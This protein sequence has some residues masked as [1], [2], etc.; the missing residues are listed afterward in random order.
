MRD[1]GKTLQEMGVTMALHRQRVLRGIKRLLLGLG[2]PPSSPIDVHCVNQHLLAWAP[3]LQGGSPPFH[4]YVVEV[5][6]GGSWRVVNGALTSDDRGVR[7]GHEHHH[8]HHQE[9]EGSGTVYRVRAWN[10]YG[11]SEPVVVECENSV[12]GQRAWWSGAWVSTLGVVVLS[13]VARSA[14]MLG[15]LDHT[16]FWSKSSGE[17]HKESPTAAVPPSGGLPRVASAVSSAA[18]DQA[19]PG[20]MQQPPQYTYSASFGSTGSGERFAVP[21]ESSQGA[22]KSSV[23]AFD[24]CTAKTLLPVLRIKARGTHYC[25]VCQRYY[26]AVHTAVSA[27]GASG[28]CGVES[29]CVCIGC[30]DEMDSAR[31]A[32]VMKRRRGSLSERRGF[33][34]SGGSTKSG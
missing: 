1:G 5:L 9:G 34:A 20:Y 8:H 11:M 4:K 16:L 10:E 27:H 13:I 19:H 17:R 25:G 32:E 21:D 26:C 14:Y 24:E 6:D 22:K 3:P 18:S 28:D 33:A 23:C 2:S 30:L 7:V 31:R 29:K 12:G 15:W